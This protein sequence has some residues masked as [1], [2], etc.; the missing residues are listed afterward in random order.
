MHDILAERGVDE[1]RMVL[2]DQAKTTKGNF[3][4]AAAMIDPAD[5]VVVITS[6]Y[7]MDRA[8]KTARAAGFTNILR[9]PAPSSLPDFGVNVMWEVVMELNELTLKKN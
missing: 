7:H 6:H 9:L 8:V 1:A 3:R 2:E 4:N 5:P